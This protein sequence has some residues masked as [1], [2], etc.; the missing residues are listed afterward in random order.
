[1]SNN[2]WLEKLKSQGRLI[3]N[4]GVNNTF[5]S[6]NPLTKQPGGEVLFY[7]VLQDDGNV[8]MNILGSIKFPDRYLKKIAQSENIIYAEHIELDTVYIDKR[9]LLKL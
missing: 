9:Y 7:Y 5:N 3:N 4:T 1:M 8:V 2:D 6:K